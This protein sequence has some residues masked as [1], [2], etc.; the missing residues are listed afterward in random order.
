MRHLDESIVAFVGNKI[1]QEEKGDGQA[2][3]RM[4]KDKYFGSGVQP[5]GI[6]LDKFLELKFRY[7]D[8]WS[9]D[10]RATTRQMTLTGTDVN[11]ELVSILAI[12]TLPNK[13]ESLIRI[14]TYGNQYPTTEETIVNFE[15]DQAL[16]QAK[17]E[18]KDGVAFSAARETRS[19]FVCGKKGHISRNC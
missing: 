3:W 2:L 4:L 1:A 9:E 12:R 14:L 13:Y 11:N 5:Q 7:L 10:L 8:Q 18:V 19:C 15:K 6:T 17:G 16:F